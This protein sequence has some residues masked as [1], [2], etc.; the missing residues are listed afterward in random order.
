M[1]GFTFHCLFKYSF[2][3]VN[4]LVFGVHML[5]THR[6]IGASLAVFT[7]LFGIVGAHKHT[8]AIDGEKKMTENICFH[9]LT[10]LVAFWCHCECLAR[11]SLPAIVSHFA[12][13]FRIECLLLR[14]TDADQF[15]REHI[16]SSMD[17]LCTWSRCLNT[18]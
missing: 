17:P 15:R 9:K 14:A 2:N 11:E 16:I 5:G 4:V 8:K 18:I 1:V 12:K 10:K 7:E 3:L 6:P 13:S